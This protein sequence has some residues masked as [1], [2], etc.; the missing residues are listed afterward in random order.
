MA[1]R[2][3]G[4]F[5]GRTTSAKRRTSWELGPGGVTETQVT[6]TGSVFLGSV[7]TPLL[8]GLTLAR[9]RGRFQAVIVA[10]SAV[11]SGMIGAF[12]IGIA[13]TAAVTVGATAVPTPITEQGWDGWL[14]WM[15]LQVS[16]VSATI[17][18]GAN[19]MILAQLLEVDTK[20]MRKLTVEDSIYA[21][22]EISTEHDIVTL[23][24]N[25]DSRALIFLP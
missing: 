8:D 7:A 20:A 21:M 14:F 12:G 24:M 16:V 10:A 17:S 23:A 1:T 5:R 6:T 9:I 4:S 13:T 18:D 19:A 2:S 15:P 11:G 25:F 3:R 22:V